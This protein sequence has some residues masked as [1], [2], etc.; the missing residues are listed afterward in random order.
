ME[1]RRAASL[2]DR[3]GAYYVRIQAM[4]VKHHIPLEDEFD[5]HDG[6][7]T[8]YVIVLDG[9]L[10]VATARMYGAGEDAAMIG[11]IV[12]LPEY[13]R[14]GLGRLVVRSCEEWAQELGYTKARVESRDS[15]VGFYEKLGY[16]VT[17]GG[18]IR[19]KT[20]SCVPM[21]KPL[22]EEE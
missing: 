5:A 3:A 15:K 20:F 8:H 16:R 2:A 18:L 19:G 10:P 4:A 17:G 22:A 21:E 9:V 7:D 11:R 13:R 1:V 6:E 14:Q 12:V